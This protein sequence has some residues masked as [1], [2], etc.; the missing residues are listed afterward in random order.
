MG[1]GGH[2]Y[3]MKDDGSGTEIISPDAVTHLMTVSPDGRWAAAIISQPASGGGGTRLEFM[4]L[5]G[6]KSFEVCNDACSVGPRSLLSVMPFNWST[7]GKW[8]FVNLVHFGKN[9]RRTVV[10][11]YRSD[12]PPETLWPKGLRFEEDVAANPGSKT[13]N[14]SA[15]FP[16]SDAAA[17]LFSRASTKRSLNFPNDKRQV[18]RFVS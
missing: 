13:I 12:L 17:Y 5:R 18:V 2:L 11:P 7:N 8:L 4:S 15:T 16:A 3:G 10:L 14:A 1:E 9:T 6:E